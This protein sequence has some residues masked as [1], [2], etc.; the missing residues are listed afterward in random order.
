MATIRIDVSD[1]TLAAIERERMARG[2]TQS[3]FVARALNGF[4]ERQSAEKTNRMNPD[5]D[6]DE[7]A[8]IMSAQV[9]AFQEGYW[10]DGYTQDSKQIAVS[11]ETDEIALS[12]ALARYAFE[13]N[14]WDD[15]GER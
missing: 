14:P 11:D 10:D 4:L 7:M 15:G 8:A 13:A 12:V 5:T 1:E 2:E 9:H 3:E 6:E